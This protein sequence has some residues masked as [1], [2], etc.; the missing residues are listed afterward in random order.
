[1]K[2][3]IVTVVADAD[4]VVQVVHDHGPDLGGGI[5]GTANLCF[6]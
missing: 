3:L 4:D 5:L 2:L 6:E 1:M